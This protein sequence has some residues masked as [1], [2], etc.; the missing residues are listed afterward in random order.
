MGFH[1]ATLIP[2]PFEVVIDKSVSPSA[3]PMT[4]HHRRQCVSAFGP[5]IEPL[6]EFG[7]AAF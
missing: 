2:F 6:L 7:Q 5:L 3:K 4:P 1:V